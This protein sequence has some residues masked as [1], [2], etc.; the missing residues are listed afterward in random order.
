MKSVGGDVFGGNWIRALEDNWRDCYEKCDRLTC[1]A[2]KRTCTEF[3]TTS[4]GESRGDFVT[5]GT[6]ESLLI[7]RPA[8]FTRRGLPRS[9]TPC[10]F[11]I[12][13]KALSVL[14]MIRKP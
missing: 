7:L 8:H 3:M 2:W 13:R 6:D 1:S 12:A 9:C 14:P 11:C 10:K 5:D 4:A